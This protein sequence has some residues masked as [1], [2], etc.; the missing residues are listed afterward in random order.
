MKPRH[1]AALA[2]VVLGFCL[3]SNGLPVIARVEIQ[4]NHRISEQAIRDHI[5]SQVGQPF[6]P[7]RVDGDIKVIYH[8]GNFNMVRVSI[9]RGNILVFTLPSASW[10]KRWTSL[11][12]GAKSST[13]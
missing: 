7:A 8:L 6:D 12:S 10:R 5:S 1:V 4:G 3:A 2:L 11:L 13:N 9:Q